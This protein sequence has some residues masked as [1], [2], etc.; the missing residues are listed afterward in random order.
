M[1]SC[2]IQNAEKCKVKVQFFN[3]IKLTLCLETNVLW[4]SEKKFNFAFNSFPTNRNRR[5][6]CVRI[7][8]FY[9]IIQ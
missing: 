4:N 3:Y 6:D 1:S 5:R 8:T 7:T 9:L 2:K